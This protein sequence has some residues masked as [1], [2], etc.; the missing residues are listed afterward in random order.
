LDQ[1]SLFNELN[2]KIDYWG[3]FGTHTYSTI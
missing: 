2:K 1:N 3:S